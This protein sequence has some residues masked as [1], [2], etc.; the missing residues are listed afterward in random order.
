M[1]FGISP[2]EPSRLAAGFECENMSRDSIQ[3]PAIVG[4]YHYAAAEILQAFLERTQSRYIEVVCRF[5]EMI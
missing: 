3:E 5:V 1:I 4:Y 2:L